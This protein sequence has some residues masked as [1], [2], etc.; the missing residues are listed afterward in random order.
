MTAACLRWA[1][2]E[3]AWRLCAARV[4]SDLIPLAAGLFNNA[5]RGRAGGDNVDE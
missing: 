3:N 1:R 2:L 5:A 4:F